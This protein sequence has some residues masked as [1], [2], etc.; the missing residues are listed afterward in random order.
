MPKWL[1]WT[2]I[3]FLIWSAMTL[4]ISI[5]YGVE[6]D[7]SLNFKL[8]PSLYTLRAPANFDHQ[9]DPNKKDHQ[10]QYLKYKEPLGHSLSIELEFEKRDWWEEKSGALPL[11]PTHW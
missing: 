7:Y 5:S 2:W 11:A 8:N 1:K 4:R 3:G 6:I 10:H 9:I